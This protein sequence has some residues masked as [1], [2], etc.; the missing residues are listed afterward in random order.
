MPPRADDFVGVGQP[1]RDEEQPRLV[2]VVIV[3][4]HDD[5]LDVSWGKVPPQSV[6]G[7]RP[8]SSP[9]EDHDPFGHG[10]IVGHT[11]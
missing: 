7:E 9:T 2:D 5:D 1:E 6:G 10:P 3:L 4:V 11:S 8:P